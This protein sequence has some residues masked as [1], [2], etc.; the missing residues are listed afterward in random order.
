MLW[1][2]NSWANSGWLSLLRTIVLCTVALS[3]ADSLTLLLFSSS[4][5]FVPSAAAS[6]GAHAAAVAAVKSPSLVG[7]HIL[8][9]PLAKLA[10][11]CLI[12]LCLLFLEIAALSHYDLT[13][14]H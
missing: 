6:H 2:L 13:N 9:S 3:W 11:V 14:K 8:I 12:S 10:S 5:I 4:H 7:E 1:S